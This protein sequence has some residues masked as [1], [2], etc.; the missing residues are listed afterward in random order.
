MK[1]S[2]HEQNMTT[3]PHLEHTREW[4]ASG[5]QLELL[6]DSHYVDPLTLAPILHLES[7]LGGYRR[8]LDGQPLCQA[9]QQLS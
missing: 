3:S 2:M 1:S 9:S 6:T 7:G 5:I 4:S 8:N